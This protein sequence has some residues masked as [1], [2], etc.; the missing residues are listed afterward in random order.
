MF[1]TVFNPNDLL[2]PI[3][4]VRCNAIMSALV[5]F[6]PQH[7]NELQRLMQ[8]G[9]KKRI[10]YINSSLQFLI[11]H[12]KIYVTNEG[13]FHLLITQELIPDTSDISIQ[14]SANFIRH[15]LTL[16]VNMKYVFDKTIK[17]IIR[18][19]NYPNVFMLSIDEKIYHIQYT[20]SFAIKQYNEFLDEYDEETNNDIST[21]RRIL[22]SDS[23][24]NLDSVTA[25]GVVNVVIFDEKGH[26]RVLR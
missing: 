26:I 10:K 5:L 12:R 9:H 3:L 21:T 1:T 4:E 6:G 7:F 19:K 16:N 22:I 24:L 20:P 2:S 8:A 11:S 18:C 14:R 17:N 13:K 23:N 15:L 25:K